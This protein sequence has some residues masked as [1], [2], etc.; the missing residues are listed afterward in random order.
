MRI[1][2]EGEAGARERGLCYTVGGDKDIFE[3]CHPVRAA[4]VKQLLE[5][6]MGVEDTVEFDAIRQPQHRSEGL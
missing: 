2:G 1:E 6:M 4:L 3:R 5:R